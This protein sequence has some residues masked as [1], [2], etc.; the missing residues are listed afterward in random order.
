[1]Q[2][3]VV[4]DNGISYT[5]RAD[6]E[7]GNGITIDVATGD[8]NGVVVVGTDI[9]VTLKSGESPASVILEAGADEIEFASSESGEGGNGVIVNLV[10][11]DSAASLPLSSVA[12]PDSKQL[13]VYLE[14]DGSTDALA[15][16]TT[17]LAGSN[18]D[19]VFTSKLDG[20]IGSTI[21]VQYIAPTVARQDT[22]ADI[23]GNRKIGVYLAATA[24]N[25]ALTTA[26]TGT[27]NDLVFTSTRTGSALGNQTEIEYIDPSENNAEL[28]IAFSGDTIQFNLATDSGGLITT[29]AD[30]IKAALL[31]DS[32]ASALVSA[33]DAPSND[34]SGVVTALAATALT[35]GG[36]LTITST[37]AQVK[38]AIE[39]DYESSLL[40]TV[41]NA[42]ANDGTGIVSATLFT[43]TGGEYGDSVSTSQEVIDAVN[44]N[45][46]NDFIIASLIAGDGTA[47][48]S[49]GS[50]VTTS[51]GVTDSPSKGVIVGLVNEDSEASDL[52]FA[53]IDQKRSGE[54]VE[55]SGYPVTLSD[56][57]EDPVVYADDVPHICS[58]ELNVPATA[59]AAS[60]TKV[61][62]NEATEDDFSLFNEADNEITIARAGYYQ[63]N[64]TCGFKSGTAG[65]RLDVT[66]NSDRRGVLTGDESSTTGTDL[67]VYT[68]GGIFWLN[69]NES[70]Y[71]QVYQSAAATRDFQEEH[72]FG[73]PQ[74]SVAEIGPQPLDFTPLL[75]A[76]IIVIGDSQTEGNICGP[77]NVYGPKLTSN[78]V[79]YGRSGY[80]TADLLGELSSITADSDIDTHIVYFAGTNDVGFTVGYDADD[81]IASVD[82]IETI[83]NDPGLAFKSRTV[84]TIGPSSYSYANAAGYEAGRTLF[85]TELV[86]RYSDFAEHIVRL[87]L[88][89]N[90][91]VN[92]AQDDLKM[93]SDKLHF[94]GRGQHIL[95]GLIRDA[96][97][98]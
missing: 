41:A 67:P 97:A 63:I 8:V 64:A 35:G 36:A 81:A 18:N 6:G 72:L 71:L 79:N 95:A 96:L 55:F 83:L 26:L 85:N 33:V 12:N 38:A 56:G 29:T 89:P 10:K 69:E 86:S 50:V 80:T 54:P 21:S 93:F 7:A 48:V 9:T 70:V 43:L 40:V 20:P 91:G 42:A 44:G 22:V 31:A 68:P 17:A 66:I 75:N 84:I 65:D 16:F 78:C 3:S 11:R 24:G 51:G 88:N 59:A 32:D 2:A 73:R 61:P 47:V 19:L 46:D 58:A 77:V 4:D 1:M 27:N 15:S 25:A 49:S 57:A 34:G 28:S 14:I 60:S 52:V 23:I 92:G 39:A 87:D 53:D 98:S 82:N 90:I 37:A 74:L 5:A 30:D 45:P 13:T 76:R 62:L 94:T